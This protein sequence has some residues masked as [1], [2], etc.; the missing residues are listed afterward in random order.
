[1]IV[2]CRALGDLGLGVISP[3]E[4]LC[5]SLGV[6]LCI[7]LASNKDPT[8]LPMHILI[9]LYSLA[10]LFSEGFLTSTDCVNPKMEIC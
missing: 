9:V 6:Q 8:L 10:Y 5:F 1:M 4:H 7:E 3:S 2:T